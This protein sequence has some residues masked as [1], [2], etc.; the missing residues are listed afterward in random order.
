MPLSFI[1]YYR[2]FVFNLSNSLFLN[3]YRIP[4]PG[5]SM[6]IIPSS[7]PCPIFF[8]CRTALSFHH[9]KTPSSDP[10]K[11]EKFRKFRQNIKMWVRSE[12]KQY[13]KYIA[14]DVHFNRKRF[15]YIFS[16][17]IKKK[18]IPDKLLWL[19]LVPSPPLSES[20]ELA[21]FKM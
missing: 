20:L 7:Q 4:L 12:R 6:R 11:M 3:I 1:F 9:F 8:Y 16:F 13:L 2:E 21:P 5:A 19:V 15:W 17:K 14:N 10:A 18:P